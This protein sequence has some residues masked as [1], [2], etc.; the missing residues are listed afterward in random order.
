MKQLIYKY[1]KIE[2]YK[3]YKLIIYKNKKRLERLIDAKNYINDN[4][5]IPLSW[6]FDRFC[7]KLEI[8]MDDASFKFLT[9][10][11]MNNNLNL[12]EEIKKLPL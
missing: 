6:L 1:L 4:S 3:R 5:D 7:Q 8:Q 10:I 12:I 2:V 9:R 11:A